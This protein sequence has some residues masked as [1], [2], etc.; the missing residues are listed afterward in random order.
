MIIDLSRPVVTFPE[1]QPA[2]FCKPCGVFHELNMT[3]ESNPQ[4]QMWIWN[5]DKYQPSFWPMAKFKMREGHLC[6]FQVTDG[7]ITYQPDSTHQY[8]GSTH[9]LQPPA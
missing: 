2:V 3:Q 4:G 8:A 5:G 6:H 7:K 9:Y 1:G